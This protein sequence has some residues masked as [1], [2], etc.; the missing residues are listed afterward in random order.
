[1]SILLIFICS[2]HGNDTQNPDSP[3][4]V[5]GRSFLISEYGCY[6]GRS[7]LSR[8]GWVLGRLKQIG[9]MWDDESHNYRR[10]SGQA[11]LEVLTS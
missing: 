8:V 10:S 5:K 6:A 3:E 4:G 7:I 9:L 11:L 1:M 2:Y